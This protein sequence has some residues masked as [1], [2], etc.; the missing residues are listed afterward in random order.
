LELRYLKP[1]LNN[2]SCEIAVPIGKADQSWFVFIRI[3]GAQ[4]GCSGRQMP[5]GFIEAS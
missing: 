1:A 5:E 3:F 2:R 4:D